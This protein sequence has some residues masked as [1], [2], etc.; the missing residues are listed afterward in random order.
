MQNNAKNY[1]ETFFVLRSKSICVENGI[2]RGEK[3]IGVAFDGD[4]KLI[5]TSSTRSMM[6]ASLFI[7][8][9]WVSEAK[10]GAV[11]VEKEGRLGHNLE[12]FE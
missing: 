11:R 8:A 5:D 1:R 10:P 12:T 2:L 3:K 7:D 9:D 6:R 4:V